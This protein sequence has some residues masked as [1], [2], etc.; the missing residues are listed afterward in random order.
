MFG[1]TKREQRW[2]AEQQAA[3]VLAGLAAVAIRGV[4]DAR[5]AEAQVDTN[6]LS[7]LRGLYEELLF[8]VGN[9]Y[10]G[11]TRHQTALRYIQ[12]AEAPRISAAQCEGPN[13]GIEPP[14]E[15]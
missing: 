14:L 5:I 3:E 13:V 11:E 15:K 6:E 2:K 10:P 1:L 7:R 8:A 4:A 9:K 12:Q